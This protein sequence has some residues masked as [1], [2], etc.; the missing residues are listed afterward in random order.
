[1]EVIILAKLLAIREGNYTMYVF[2]NIDSNAYIMC[3]RMPNW[4]VPDV[5]IGDEGFLKYQIVNAGETYYN[6]S[7]NETCTYS[8]SN[9][10][11]LNFVLRSNINDSNI[12]L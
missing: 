8:Y 10:Y 6:S 5:S 12:I 1:M 9:I 2:K 4:Q 3:T 11:F 7:T